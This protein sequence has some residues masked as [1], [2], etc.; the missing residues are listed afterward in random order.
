MTAVL[1]LSI[2][3]NTISQF[4]GNSLKSVP[5]DFPILIFLSYLSFPQSS[6]SN[7]ELRIRGQLDF[8]SWLLVGPYNFQNV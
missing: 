7:T 1:D 8:L 2:S 4:R 3:Y 6:L 5:L